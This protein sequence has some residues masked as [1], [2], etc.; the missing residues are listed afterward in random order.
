M[1]CLCH[2]G[3]FLACPH[4][5][6][7]LLAK[8]YD[9]LPRLPPPILEFSKSQPSSTFCS[10]N[11]AIFILGQWRCQCHLLFLCL[12]WHQACDSS[13]NIP[14]VWGLRRVKYITPPTDSATL[15][16]KEIWGF[17]E[18]KLLSQKSEFC[19]FGYIFLI[20]YFPSLLSKCIFPVCCLI[21]K[22]P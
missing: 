5:C 2:P 22:W 6:G 15:R 11:E 19:V 7:N 10:L 8:G 14:E 21:G 17:L 1:G 4:F 20:I 12:C 13:L 16:V 3:V 9:F 18:W